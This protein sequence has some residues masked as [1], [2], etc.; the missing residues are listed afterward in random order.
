M[1]RQIV[2]EK[3]LVTEEHLKLWTEDARREESLELLV[4]QRARERSAA[5]RRALDKLPKQ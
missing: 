1:F 2:I 5:F 3:E 4:E